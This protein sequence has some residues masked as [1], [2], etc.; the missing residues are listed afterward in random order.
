MIKALVDHGL[1]VTAIHSH[2]LYETPRLFFLHFWGYDQPEKLA[3]G[4]KAALEKTN[5]V[6]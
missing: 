2:M 3:T 6:H 5:S 1:T 4:L